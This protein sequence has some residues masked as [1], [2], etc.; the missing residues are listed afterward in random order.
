[1][2]NRYHLH[3]GQR[4]ATLRRLAQERLFSPPERRTAA[5]E[6]RQQLRNEIRAIH[7]QPGIEAQATVQKRH[8]DT[9]A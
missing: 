9:I 8:T 7:V 2:M 6:C 3:T 1:M 5:L 4:F